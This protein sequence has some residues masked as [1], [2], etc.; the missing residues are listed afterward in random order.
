MLSVFTFKA[1]WSNWCVFLVSKDDPFHYLLSRPM[2]ESFYWINTG[3][4]IQDTIQNMTWHLWWDL[5]TQTD[6]YK[7][8]SHCAMK[9]SVVFSSFY[10]WWKKCVLFSPSQL[11]LSRSFFFLRFICD[12]D[13]VDENKIK[14]YTEIGNTIKHFW[15]VYSVMSII[16]Q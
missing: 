13:A 16:Q 15:I 6:I 1:I 4:R 9:R 2:I 12:D 5:K 3:S 14:K 7:N 11:C 10:F 8:N